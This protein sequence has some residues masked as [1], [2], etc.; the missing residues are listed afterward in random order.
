LEILNEDPFFLNSNCSTEYLSN[1]LWFEGME[2][3][4]TQAKGY[5]IT[6]PSPETLV[7][8][9]EFV[10]FELLTVCQLGNGVRLK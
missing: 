9:C 6:D 4:I 8:T 2:N 5:T 7:F 3:L 10:A 1:H